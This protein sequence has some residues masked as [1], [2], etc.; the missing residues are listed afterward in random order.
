MMHRSL[1]LW[2]AAL[3]VAIGIFSAG[4]ANQGKQSGPAV[5]PAAAKPAA[6][7]EVATTMDKLTDAVKDGFYSQIGS[8]DLRNLAE[9]TEGATKY[10]RG[11]YTGEGHVY[12][13]RIAADGKVISKEEKVKYG[14]GEPK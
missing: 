13:V 12:E 9:V 5:A 11:E 10:Y 3:C 7:K 8:N 4:C 6:P 1:G 2:T 14:E